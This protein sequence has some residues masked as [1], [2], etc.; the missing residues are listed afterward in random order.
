MVKPIYFLFLNQ[1]IGK[2][3][4]LNFGYD[5]EGKEREYF[6]KNPQNNG[7]SFEEH[8]IKILNNTREYKE[9]IDTVNRETSDFYNDVPIYFKITNLFKDYPILRKYK[10][11]FSEYLHKISQTKF[12][13]KYKVKFMEIEPEYNEETKRFSRGKLT[14][15]FYNMN[16]FQQI[17]T[18]DLEKDRMELN[19]K[20]PLG[21]MILHNTLML[22]TDWIPEDALEL[23]KNAYFIYKRFI[24]NRVSGKNKPEEIRLWFEDIKSFLDMHWGN[25]RGIH[26]TIDKAFKAILAKGLV[27]GYS[28]NKDRIFRQYVLNFEH[29]QKGIVKQVNKG[30]EVMTLPI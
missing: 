29:P 3:L 8:F 13:M 4:A 20:T 1:Q 7:I 25:D 18:V 22:D 23:S 11:K 9:F 14:D 16:D 5:V 2:A 12:Q 21:K 6:E 15:I 27:R 19:F 24:L 28:W 10:Y 30:D 17:F 26:A